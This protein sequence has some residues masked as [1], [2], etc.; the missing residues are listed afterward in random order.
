VA[1]VRVTSA[2][3]A[4][5]PVP[6]RPVLAITST[7]ILPG[8]EPAPVAASAL[9][10][11]IVPVATVLPVEVTALVVVPAPAVLPVEVTGLVV[12]PAP[13]VTSSGAT[14]VGTVAPAELPPRA[15][16][17]GPAAIG[18]RTVRLSLIGAVTGG[19]GR[20]AAEAAALAAT[21]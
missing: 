9:V 21:C 15:I 16:G 3:A 19:S 2:E 13:A 17:S 11:A 10:A 18:I 20:L 5:A 1:T 8:A 6:F 7:P 14:A 12:L 4:A